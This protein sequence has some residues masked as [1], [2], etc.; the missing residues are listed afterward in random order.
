MLEAANQHYGVAM[1]MDFKSKSGD[2]VLQYEVALKDGLQCG[3]AY[4]K[5]LEKT[6]DLDLATFDDKTPFVV[7][8]GPDKCGSTDKVHFILRQQ[9]P[10]SKEWVEHHLV[11][12]PRPAGDK[13][14][15]LYTAVIKADD[16]LEIFIDGVSKF[17]GSMH[18]S[19]EPALTPDQEID[20]PEDSKPADWVDVAKIDDPEAAK[21][22]DWDE[23]APKQ[24]D[25]STAAKPDGWLDDEPAVVADPAA[26]MPDDWDADE[27]GDWE[28]PEIT[29][30]KC[31][32]GCGEWVRPRIAN[33]AYKGKWVAPKIDNPAYKGPWAPR[34][35]ANPN[36]FEAKDVAKGLK[37]IGAMA[38]EVWTTN[39]Q[40]SFDNFAVSS[41]AAEAA[42]LAAP[43]YA[44]KAAEEAAEEE[45]K[46]EKAAK[47]A[48][49][50]ASQFT[51]KLDAIKALATDQPAAAAASGAVALFTVL[52][53]VFGGKKTAVAAP[54][55]APAKAD[56]DDKD[57]AKTK[58]PRAD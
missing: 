5:M 49:K 28:A 24:I 27:D 1:P 19:F 55:S 16:T 58:T 10:V 31:A 43:F 9:N 50:R 14:S 26:K 57:A 36:Y 7:M 42:T 54:A 21:P 46:A 52:Y 37:P 13:S 17:V 8:F 34:K 23:D 25:D 35:I 29:N 6:A 51:A 15:H 56:D 3:G 48:A 39:K 41:D 11:K 38:V 40:L 30:P 33:P 4:V 47:K 20:D 12:A 44:K 18:E 53:L 22:D 32:V 45:K 2:T